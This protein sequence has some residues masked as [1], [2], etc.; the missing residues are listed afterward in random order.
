MSQLYST[1]FKKIER[2]NL[3]I[4]GAF[5][6]W[7]RGS[8]FPSTGFPVYTADRWYQFS[9]VGATTAITTAQHYRS[10][11]AIAVYRDVGQSFTDR[12]Y[13]CQP[14]QTKL[15]A[16]L[17]GK[18]MTL[19]FM[20][21]SLPGFS[22]AGGQL[23]VTL[24]SGTSAEGRYTGGGNPWTGHQALIDDQLVSLGPTITK[25]TLTTE[26]P[27]QSGAQQMELIFSYIP[28]G[29]AGAD[30]AFSLEQVMLVEGTQPVQDFYRA[31]VTE[32]SELALCRRF[33]E[34]SWPVGTPPGTTTGNGAR[35]VRQDGT[36]TG[37]RVYLGHSGEFLVEKRAIP[38]ITI[39]N[40]RGNGLPNYLSRYDADT[41]AEI[42]GGNYAP[43]TKGI[44]GYAQVDVSLA[45][46][47]WLYH[48]EADA[49]L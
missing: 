19:S 42:I 21:R 3:V 25:F 20:A 32:E 38:A 39:W 6:F 14:F 16:P 8:S 41:N 30:D 45:D 17:R 2:P 40:H 27:M 13:I 9:V 43:N 29:T 49:E 7:Q 34:K 12:I 26:V 5:D 48:F 47:T 33:Y 10:S 1:I 31:G 28:V 46:S 4:N 15:I 36:G 35:S 37:D 11:G 18:Y 24:V 44:A 22:A 23:I